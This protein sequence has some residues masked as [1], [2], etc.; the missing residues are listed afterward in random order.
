MW[1]VGCGCGRVASGVWACVRACVSVIECGGVGVG[2]GRWCLGL[3]LR[4]FLVSGGWLLFCVGGEGGGMLGGWWWQ[5]EG[6][7]AGWLDGVDAS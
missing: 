4:G 6:A 2:E 1:V 3:A 7:V 5:R